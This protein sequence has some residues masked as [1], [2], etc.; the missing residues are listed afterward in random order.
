MKVRIGNGLIPAAV[1]VIVLIAAITLSFSNNLRIILGLLLVVFTPGYVLTVALFPKKDDLD[2]V[3]RVALSFVMSITVVAL[4]GLVI[5]YTPWG[6]RLYPVVGALA[7]FTIVIATVAWYRWRKLA[8]VDR[9]TITFNIGLP[10]WSTQSLLNKTLSAI[11]AIVIL[12]VMGVAVFVVSSPR[13]GE[14]FTEF[15]LL[16]FE[17]K[18]EDYPASI[19]VGDEGTVILVIVNREHEIVSYKVEVTIDGKENRV[20]G[21]VALEHREKWQQEV[22]FILAEIGKRQKV[23]FSLY[24]DQENDPYLPPLH[25]WVDG[26]E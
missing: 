20:V 19:R 17:G 7:I 15:Y 1:L 24:R 25:L 14:R 6:I 2:G 10:A 23:E 4:L 11:L 12:G 26:I 22:D 5:N 3:E 9:F 16:G 21:P 8:D 18:A 13:A